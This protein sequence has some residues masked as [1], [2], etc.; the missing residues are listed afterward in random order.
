MQQQALVY[1]Q[2]ALFNGPFGIGARLMQQVSAAPFEG[3]WTPVGAA[4]T[5]SIEVNQ[6]GT[7]T[8]TL[9]I[10][11]RNTPDLPMNT[12]TIT[13]GGSATQNDVVTATFA[14]PNL[15]GGSEAV[16]YTVGA[17]PTLNSVAAAL[18]A[19]ITADANLSALGFSA[20][21]TGAVITVQFPSIA[22]S[23]AIGQPADPALGNYTQITTSLSGG[24]TET[25]TVAVGADGFS[26]L[27]INAIGFTAFPMP[28]NYIKARLTALTGGGTLT[29]D[30]HGAA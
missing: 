30:F 11:G 1:N 6:T 12:Y 3:L 18:A 26:L 19:L 16:S 9:G 5:S 15:P 27:S 22:G 17:T 28:V 25:L 2:S 29:A 14:N 7:P 23:L 24:A 13:V 20:T 4:K 8:F 21:A 10:W